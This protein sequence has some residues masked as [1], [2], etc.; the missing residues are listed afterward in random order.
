VFC[1]TWWG[2]ISVCVSNKRI[3]NVNGFV[4]IIKEY[5]CDLFWWGPVDEQQ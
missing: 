2:L 5:E 4:W 3:V 1:F